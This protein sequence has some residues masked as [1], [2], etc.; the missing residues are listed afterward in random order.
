MLDTQSIVG[1]RDPESDLSLRSLNLINH[2]FDLSLS[3]CKFDCI[4]QKVKQHL[5]NSLDISFNQEVIIFEA[6]KERT[7]LNLHHIHLVFLHFNNFS[8]SFSDVKYFLILGKIFV[9]IVEH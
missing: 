4:G 2:D 9:A 3:I 8:N 6:V 7:V 1:N 5:L